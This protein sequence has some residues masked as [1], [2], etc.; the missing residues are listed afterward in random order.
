VKKEEGAL[1]S[2]DHEARFFL[3]A[4]PVVQ[5]GGLLAGKNS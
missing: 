2:G 3:G 1:P 5:E 4:L